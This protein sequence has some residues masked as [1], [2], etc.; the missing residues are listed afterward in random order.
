MVDR[1]SRDSRDAVI[2]VSDFVMS[3]SSCRLK[4]H[5]VAADLSE[6]VELLGNLRARPVVSQAF[7]RP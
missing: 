1:R 4:M 2:C 3:N 5:N 7:W 6:F